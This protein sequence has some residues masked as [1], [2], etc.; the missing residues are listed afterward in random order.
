[1]LAVVLPVLCRARDTG[2]V[3]RVSAGVT[4]FGA[5]TSVVLWQTA[6]W[7][8]PL[9]YGPAYAPAVP[10]FRV[11]SLSFPLFS[12]NYALT[13]QLIGWDRQ[14]AYAFVCATALAVNVVV[15]ASLIPSWSIEGAAWATFW[16]EAV[17]T[18]GCAAALWWEVAPDTLRATVA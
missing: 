2:P 17:V 16:T 8:I 11:L 14:R 1:M 3:V 13:H 6:D 18:V 12:L 4:L 15:N 7:T 9:V 5:V 10:A